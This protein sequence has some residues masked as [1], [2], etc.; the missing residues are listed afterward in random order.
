MEAIDVNSLNVRLVDR[1]GKT[2]DNKPHFRLVWSDDMYEM[3]T[4]CRPPLVGTARVKKYEYLF[5]RWILEM[6]ANNPPPREVINYDFYEPL[7]VFEDK[8]GNPLPPIWKAIEFV[9]YCKLNPW[10]KVK[11]RLETELMLDAEQQADVNYFFDMFDIT[12][13]QSRFMDRTA[14]ILPGKEIK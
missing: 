4:Y 9:I 1:Y 10:D 11:R 12:P 13:L 3:R 8:N 14:V 2:I 6:W 7:W 5:H